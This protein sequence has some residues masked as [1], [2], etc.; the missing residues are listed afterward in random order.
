MQVDDVTVVRLAGPKVGLDARESLYGLIDAQGAHKLV[1]NF[2]RVKLLTSA[3]IGMLI[4]LRNKAEAR[5]GSVRF[6]HVDSDIRDI[7]QLTAV[8]GLF[9]IFPTEQDAIDSFQRN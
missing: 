1:L 5:G 2:E 4:S 9:P 7:L 3:P 8:E 6:C